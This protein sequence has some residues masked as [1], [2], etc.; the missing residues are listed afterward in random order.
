MEESDPRNRQRSKNGSGSRRTKGVTDIRVT[1]T[2]PVPAQML[3]AFAEL[4]AL[5]TREVKRMKGPKGRRVTQRGLQEMAIRK[6]LNKL[7]AQ[8]SLDLHGARHV[9]GKR[10][11][12][13]LSE[14]LYEE[15]QE[16]AASRNIPATYIFITAC[17]E[18]LQS[19]GYLQ[20]T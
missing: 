15:M 4:A 8:K 12:F 14:D 5:E 1:M 13:W 7:S 11:T 3:E 10:K 16:A 20:E 19:K 18:F 9:V 2:A 6:L 17:R